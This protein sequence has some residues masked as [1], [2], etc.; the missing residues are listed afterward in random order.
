M[1][2]RPCVYLETAAAPSVI[3]IDTRSLCAFEKLFDM[4]I[5]LVLDIELVER[6]G[7]VG[8]IRFMA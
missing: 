2:M 8:G 4:P 3:S 1:V 7:V 5:A 6:P